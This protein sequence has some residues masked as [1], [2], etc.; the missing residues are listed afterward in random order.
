[1]GTAEP[2]RGCVIRVHL[3]Q[4]PVADALASASLTQ[5]VRWPLPTQG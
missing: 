2:F 5:H 1:M 4:S 3:I